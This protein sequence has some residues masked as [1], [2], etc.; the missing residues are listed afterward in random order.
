MIIEILC[1]QLPETFCEIDHL[2]GILLR[3]CR[4]H[5]E[6][7]RRSYDDSQLCEGMYAESDNMERWFRKNLD[8]DWLDEDEMM[9]IF[10]LLRR[11]ARNLHKLGTSEQA[12]VLSA[13]AMAEALDRVHGRRFAGVFRG[14]GQTRVEA[15]D[16]MPIPHPPLKELFAKSLGTNPQRLGPQLDEL[17]WLRLMPDVARG[18]RI[19][20][21]YRHDSLLAD[22][23][24]DSTIAVLLPCNLSDVHSDKVV[25]PSP[26]FFAV[27]PRKPEKQRS[28]VFGML[29]KVAEAGVRIAL[30]PEL[31]LDESLLAEVA[32]WHRNTKHELS[33]LV[34]GSV[35]CERNGKR[36]NVTTTLLPDGSRV[37]HFKFNPFYLHMGGDDGTPPANYREDIVTTP[38]EISIHMCAD[39]SFTTLICKDFLEPGVGRILEDTRVRLVLVPACSPKTTVFAQIAGMLA[40]RSQAIVVVANMANLSEHDPASAIVARPTKRDTVEQVWR[41]ALEIPQLLYFDLAGK[42]RH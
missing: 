17:H 15:G 1:S 23:R 29:N 39:W 32:E 27:R 18:H 14:R 21:D 31:A 5:A 36:R 9:W 20:L 26:R 33:L 42:L 12:A 38:S 11:S 7:L 25:D 35:H 34:C 16:P 28:I 8:E 10:G 4:E 24:P 41:D 30:L 19:I 37:E 13:R 40:A 3:F 6:A 2:A 22:L